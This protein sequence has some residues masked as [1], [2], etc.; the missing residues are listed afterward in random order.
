MTTIKQLLFKSSFEYSFVLGYASFIT[1]NHNLMALSLD[2]LEQIPLIRRKYF[3]KVSQLAS[4]ETISTVIH[5]RKE[6]PETWIWQQY[7]RFV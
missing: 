5:V 4:V 7:E 6:F 3:K 1:K 2:V